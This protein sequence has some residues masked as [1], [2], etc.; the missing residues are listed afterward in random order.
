MHKTGHVGAAFGL[1]GNAV[2]VAPHGD[3]AVLQILGKAGGADHLAEA[4][5]HALVGAADLPADLMQFRR[6]AV[7]DFLLAD[8]GGGDIVFDAVQRGKAG[9]Q[10]GQN[11]RILAVAH[12]RGAGCARGAQAGGHV[13]QRA[14][15][16][17]CALLGQRHLLAHVGKGH[18]RLSAQIAEQHA[19]FLGFI[20]RPAHLAYIIVGHEGQAFFL[21]HVR[22]GVRGQALADFGEFQHAK[23]AVLFHKGSF[24]SGNGGAPAIPRRAP[25]GP[26]WFQRRRGRRMRRRAAPRRR[27]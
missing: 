4:V 24:L 8:N 6:G 25:N 5:A 13:Q 18:Q 26:K 14:L 16:E 10:T 1:Y 21:A 11:G 15:A 23:G 27:A 19:G 3:N 2:A 20:Q 12:Q 7:R 9:S 17:A 22:Q